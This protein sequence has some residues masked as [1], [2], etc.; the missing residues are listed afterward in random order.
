MR[1]S[2]DR[3]IAESEA[4]G[5]QPELLE[6]TFHLLA[7]LDAIISHPFLRGKL[8][9]KGGTAL[10]L[11]VFAVPRLSVDIDLNY[12][13]A[14]SR[15][16]MLAERPG[17]EEALQAVFHREDYAIRR[18]PDDSHAGGKWS[19][20][21]TTAFGLSGRIDV[22]VNYMYRVP[23]WP[24]VPRV[25][26]PLGNWSAAEFPVVDLYEL[27][28]G[29]LAALFARRTA[30]DLFDSSLIF[31]INDLDIERLRVAFVLY[32]AMN[33]SDWRR[34]SADDIDFDPLEVTRQL[35]PALHIDGAHEHLAA[36]YGEALVEECRTG[37]SA[38]LPFTDSERCFLDTVLDQGQISPELLT[39]DAELQGRI[40]SQPL[41]AWKAQN[42]R[43]HRGLP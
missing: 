8:A 34:I 5:F 26:C 22:D 13:G 21:Y 14:E 33:R 16:D 29:K 10:N 42:V 1:I 20:R 19:L 37:L 39:D 27:A 7:L 38:L 41:L 43:E 3:L 23:L 6:K 35:L 2:A 9:L 12:V 36:D 24:V 11:F 32:G 18:T 31:S 4:T 40:L 17:I 15:E 28:A 25:S 30:R